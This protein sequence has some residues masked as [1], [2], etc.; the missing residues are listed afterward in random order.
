MLTPF[1]LGKDVKRDFRKIPFILGI[2]Y[3]GSW[4]GTGF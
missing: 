1:S 3:D 2:L 4:A